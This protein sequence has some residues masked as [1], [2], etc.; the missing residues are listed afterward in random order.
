M[1]S[2]KASPLST[3]RSRV[4]DFTELETWKHAQFCATSCIVW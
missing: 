1:E 4:T 2:G 3:A